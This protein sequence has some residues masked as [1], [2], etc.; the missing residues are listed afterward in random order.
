M[1]EK[2]RQITVYLQGPVLLGDESGVGNYEQ[3]LNYIPGAVLRG[4]LATH[5]L[6]AD[7]QAFRCIFETAEHPPRF[8]NAYPAWPEVWAYPFPATART[9]KQHPGYATS[10]HE[11]HGVFDILVEQTLYELLSD[12][13]FPHRERLLPALGTRWVELANGYDP[14]CPYGRDKK[15]DE[16]VNPATGYYVLRSNKPGLAPELQISRATHVGITA[17]AVWPRTTCSLHWKQSR[18]RPTS[19]LEDSWCMTT[20]VK[21]TWND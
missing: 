19:S 12:P 20:V 1:T 4:V 17:R 18:T 21:M 2:A 9:C 14:R 7:E 5:I 8:G 10:K 16:P 13:R 11:G 15:C 6:H 3:T